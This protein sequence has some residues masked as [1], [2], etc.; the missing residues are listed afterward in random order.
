MLCKK[1]G[2]EKELSHFLFSKR[3]NR[4]EGWCRACRVKKTLLWRREHIVKH[5]E[6][7]AAY[8][9]ALRKKEP[10][11]MRLQNMRGSAS[12]HA[13]ILR[14]PYEITTEYLREIYKAQNGRCYYTGIEMII[15]G[16][17]KTDLFLMSCDR[18]DSTKGYVKGNV[19]LCCF[20][21]NMLKG[22]QAPEEMFRCLRLFYEGAVSLGKI[23]TS[24]SSTIPLQSPEPPPP[25][26]HS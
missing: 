22:K 20:G 18:I 12:Q 25:V 3:R 23:V 5:R 19:V 1:C 8:K 17:R 15:N 7:D 2:E 13:K 11:S 10:F 6:H 21:L 14:L 24:C 16:N 9:R 4:L 26:P